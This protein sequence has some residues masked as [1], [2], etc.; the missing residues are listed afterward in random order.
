MNR[1]TKVLYVSDLDGTLLNRQ[2]V[3]SERSAQLLQAAID[4]GALFTIATAR[5]PATVDGLMS[6]IRGSLPYV[7]MTG[8]AMWHNHRLVNRHYMQAERLA[9]LRDICSQNG[10]RPFY[11]FYNEEEEII[12]AYHSPQMSDA[13]RAFYL[14]RANA[15][16]K[17]FV[18]SDRIPDSLLGS[19]MLTFAIGDY[20]RIVAAHAQAREVLPCSMTCY[21]D[22]FDAS[23]GL[24][25]VMAHGVSKAAAVAEISRS[26][27]ADEIVVFGDSAND[28]SMKTIAT[29]FVAPANAAQE[30]LAVADEIIDDNTTDSVARY[31]ADR[32]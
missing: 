25:E 4:R 9:A 23:I 18:I 29:R 10:I 1:P 24:F 8:A 5:T 22:I 30:V 19:A 6:Q 20:D 17:R 3:V 14:Q 12:N 2:S 15:P 27:A 26:V 31:I 32:V 11:Y 28:L 16:H 13:E 21:R 7:V